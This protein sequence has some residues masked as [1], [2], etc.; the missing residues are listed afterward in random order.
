[1]KRTMIQA[2]MIAGFVVTTTF[3]N[4]FLTTASAQTPGEQKSIYRPDFARPFTCT[5]GTLTGAYGVL[6]KGKTINLMGVPDKNYA[7]VALVTFDGRGNFSSSK[8]KANNNGYIAPLQ[9]ES[10]T[11]TLDSDCNG[12]MSGTFWDYDFVVWKDGHEFDVIYVPKTGPMTPA[13]VIF[14]GF[15]KKVDPYDEGTSPMDR[16]KSFYCSLGILA[17]TWSMSFEGITNDFPPLPPGPFVGVATLKY[18]SAGAFTGLNKAV[19]GGFYIVAPQNGQQLYVNSDCT[20]AGSGDVSAYGVLVNG[21]KEWLLL[22][23][24]PE[25]INF[26]DGHGIITTSHGKKVR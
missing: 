5:Q 19:F 18:D 10:G 21:G 26:P 14:S 4:S 7:A 13:P 12:K 20:T 11:Y 25:P 1:M 15:G 17:G 9:D 16:A 6:V 24:Y 23:T 2:L 3:T 22:G 8:G